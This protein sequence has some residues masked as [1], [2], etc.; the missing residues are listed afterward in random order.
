M[1]YYS[2]PLCILP[3]LSYNIGMVVFFCQ[4]ISFKI[5]VS[6]KYLFKKELKNLLI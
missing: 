6:F 1:S 2:A 3:T 4:E 5:K